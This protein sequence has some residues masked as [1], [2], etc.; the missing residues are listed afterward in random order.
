MFIHNSSPLN[1]SILYIFN[2]LAAISHLNHDSTKLSTMITLWSR[3]ILTV[4]IFGFLCRLWGV[5]SVDPSNMK[6]LMKKGK[7]IGMIPGGF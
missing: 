3:V 4:P 1:H 5:Q 6:R 7:T 2:D